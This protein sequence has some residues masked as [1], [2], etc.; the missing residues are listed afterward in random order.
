[1]FCGA[2]RCASDLGPVDIVLNLLVH[3]PNH[4]DVVTSHNVKTE[5]NLLGVFSVIMGPDHSFHS[6]REH[7]CEAAELAAYSDAKVVKGSWRICT[8][9]VRQLIEALKLANEHPRVHGQDHH[10]LYRAVRIQVVSSKIAGHLQFAGCEDGLTLDIACKI[11][12]L[13]ETTEDRKAIGRLQGVCYI[14]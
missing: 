9:Q 1:M 6:T 7:L 4:A 14:M 11:G 3:Q 10:L 2:D 8:Y 5:R 12:H 13:D